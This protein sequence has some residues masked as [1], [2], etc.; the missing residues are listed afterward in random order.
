MARK[1]G[2]TTR[3]KKNKPGNRARAQGPNQAVAPE[4]TPITVPDEQ[5]PDQ[6]TPVQPFEEIADVPVPTATASRRAS[7]S[8]RIRP[9]QQRKSSPTARMSSAASITIS[10]AQEY[11]FIREDL[12]RLL[13]TAGVLT[14]VM[15]GL[16][17]VIDR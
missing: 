14:V 2:Q 12:R 10:K 5:L 6:A 9:Y 15:I 1:P 13:L 17:F 3:P 11:A 8:R 7:S 4:P 16:L